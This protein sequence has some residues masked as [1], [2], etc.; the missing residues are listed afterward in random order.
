MCYFLVSFFRV[1]KCQISVLFKGFIQIRRSS[2]QICCKKFA[3]GNIFCERFYQSFSDAIYRPSVLR[4]RGE[5]RAWATSTPRISGERHGG[6]RC[7][8]WCSFNICSNPNHK[9]PQFQNILH[10]KRLPSFQSGHKQ[11][12]FR[13]TYD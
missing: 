12:R 10:V 9:Q 13:H 8:T 11:S 6:I 5:R 1:K 3:P 2:H 4:Q 7:I